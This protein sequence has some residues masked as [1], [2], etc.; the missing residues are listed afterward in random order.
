MKCNHQTRT[1]LFISPNHVEIGG[2][3]YTCYH[4]LCEKCKAY[5]CYEIYGINSPH[6]EPIISNPIIEVP[7]GAYL[8]DSIYQETLKKV[9][10]RTK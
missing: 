2:E 3:Y 8:E 9:L 6:I 4:Y 10:K 5:L 7:Y 1:L